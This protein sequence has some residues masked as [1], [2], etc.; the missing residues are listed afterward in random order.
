MTFPL[1][2]APPLAAPSCYVPEYIPAGSLLFDGEGAYLAKTFGGAGNGL[3]F[4]YSVWTYTSG[5]DSATE[6]HV[7]C[8]GTSTS[9][10]H[11]EINTRFVMFRSY[12]GGTIW[13]V[14]APLSGHPG[15][16]HILAIYDSA[17][18][19]ADDRVRLYVNGIRVI[20]TTNIQPSLNL[21]CEQFNKASV[22]WIGRRMAEPQTSRFNGGMC[23]F[24]G[25]DGVPVVCEDFGKFNEH[26]DWVIIEPNPSAFGTRGFWLDFADPNAPGNDVSGNNNDWTPNGFV[27]ADRISSTPANTY[28][29]LQHYATSVNMADGGLSGMS[30]ASTVPNGFSTLP[31]DM[32]KVTYWE[33]RIDVFAGANAIAGGVMEANTIN[34][35]RVNAGDATYGGKR[36]SITDGWNLDPYITPAP[37]AGDV[38]SFIMDGPAGTLT[39]WNNGISYGVAFSGLGNRKLYALLHHNNVNGYRSTL[40]FGQRPFVHTPPVGAVTL[41]TDNLPEPTIKDPSEGFVLE[42]ATGAN[43]EAVLSSETS[44]WGGWVEVV[45]RLT[46]STEAWRIRLSDD[47]AN[48]WSWTNGNT[49]EKGAKAAL[50]SGATYMGQRWRTGAKYG[51]YTAEIAHTNGVATTV[52][53]NLGNARGMI[54]TRRVS[55]GGGDTMLYHPE[56]AAGSLVKINEIDAAVSST[57][58]TS[59]GANSFQ[60]GSGAATGTY[61]VIV[62]VEIY[63]Y[64]SLEKHLGNANNH[65]PVGMMPLGP[66]QLILKDVSFAGS[67]FA[68]DI[69][70]DPSK[71]ATHRIEW[72]SANA[73]STTNV[74]VDLYNNGYKIRDDDTN[75]NRSGSTFISIAWGRPIGGV[76]VAPSTGS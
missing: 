26:G 21:V 34:Y 43:I 40:N 60:I 59:V 25:V 30:G 55:S 41:C 23:E 73:E 52:T 69:K 37:V 66:V 45:K 18:P 19:I 29:T 17:N 54:I 67:Y 16:S 71:H 24:V 53:H 8:A 33:H 74:V 48:S 15:F 4:A 36:Y 63:G 12:N 22:H 10:D 58:I 31:L 70:R 3:L 46:G 32:S 47:A 75:N 28:A 42:L 76:C 1:I 27:S 49:G 20:P 13:D 38:L 50:D 51:C 9:Y 61:R 56:I 65:G 57:L 7:I 64:F 11:L 35:W 6:K 62:Q 5:D 2:V 44:N 14:R 39:A 68:F 72:D